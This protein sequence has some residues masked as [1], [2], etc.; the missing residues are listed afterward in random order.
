MSILVYKNKCNPE[1][2]AKNVQYICRDSAA[3]SISFHNLDEL[4]DDD[5]TQA[6]SNAI[7]YAERREIE[8]ESRIRGNERGTPRNHNR[9]ILSF[10][11]KEETEIAK[12]EAHKFLDKEFSNQKA[13]VSVHQDKDDKTHVHVWFDCRD[14]DTGRKTQIK[15]KDFYSL[16][17]KWAKQYDEHYK[18]RYAEEYKEKKEQSREWKKEKVQ[19]GKTTGKQSRPDSK[20]ERHADQK[21]EILQSKEYKDRGIDEKATRTNKRATT[22]GRSTVGKS[23]QRIDSTKRE[24]DRAAATV[25]GTIREAKTLH[26]DIERRDI[27]RDRTDGKG[28]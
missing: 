5:K 23:Q 22:R 10:D 8:E 18:T 28:R 19:Q 17:E 20:P 26:S 24:L 9:M 14:K 21:K 15:P 13:I 1:A 16:D 7:N 4:Q 6:K 25:D 27:S 3:D 2:S 12:A 11:R